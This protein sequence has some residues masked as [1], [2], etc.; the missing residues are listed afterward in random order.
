MRYVSSAIINWY[1]MKRSPRHNHIWNMDNG[2]R[3][4]SDPKP[5]FRDIA[6]AA[7]QA[8]V[9]KPTQNV[10]FADD[11]RARRA[12]NGQRRRADDEYFAAGRLAHDRGNGIVA[13]R[14]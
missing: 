14:A 3:A 5:G 4:S 7:R 1:N 11:C 2:G 12:R 10:A 9:Q 8:A 6:A 13:R